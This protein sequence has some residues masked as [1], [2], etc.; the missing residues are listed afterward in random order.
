M[1]NFRGIGIICLTLLVLIMSVSAVTH[2]AGKSSGKAELQEHW[3][4]GMLPEE[5]P[6]STRS[7]WRH[8]LTYAP[9]MSLMGDRLFPRKYRYCVA[10]GGT[11][12]ILGRTAPPPAAW[13]DADFDDSA[14]P[15]SR[16]PMNMVHHMSVIQFSLDQ[17]MI[18]QSCFRTR[19]VVPDPGKVRKLTFTAVFHGGLIVR[20]NGREVGRM[21]I[22][23]DGILAKEGYAEPFPEEACGPVTDETKK[24]ARELK[25]GRPVRG[26]AYSYFFSKLSKQK[27]PKARGLLR[28]VR[29]LL[30]RRIEVNVPKEALRKGINVL[31]LELRLSP[32]RGRIPTGRSGWPHGLIRFVTLDAEPKNAVLS[33][34]KR[35]DGV[36]VWA[37]DI[38]RRVMTEDFL[39][40]G[41]KARSAVRILGARGGRHSAQVLVGTTKDLGAPS[42]KLSDLSGPGGA[43]IPASAVSVRWGRTLD[44][45]ATMV[46][47]NKLLKGGSG[48]EYHHPLSLALLRYRK[49]VWDFRERQERLSYPAP[50][51]L[52][53]P[54]SLFLG[55]MPSYKR[56]LWKEHA[57]GLML[58]DRLSEDP[59]GNVPADTCQPLWITAEIPA[60][61]KAGHYAG[62][63]TVSAAGMTETSFPVRLQVFDWKLPAPKRF[64]YYSG[65]DQSPWS[66]ARIAKVKLW[67]EEHW[68]L[69]EE[70]IKWCGKLGARVAALPVVRDS[71]VDNGKDTMV[72]W[73]KKEDGTYTYDFSIADRYLAL[74][75]KHCH[76]QSDVIVYVLG[77]FKFGFSIVTT[78]PGTVVVLDPETG[79]ENA[80]APIDKEATPEGIRLWVDFCKAARKHLNA[81]GISDDHILFGV[82]HDKVGETN[83][84]LI[85]AVAEELPSVGW[86]R[87][88]HHG[89]KKGKWGGKDV[90]DKVKWDTTL[91]GARQYIKRNIS[92]FAVKKKMMKIAG[93]QTWLPDTKTYQVVSHK[94]WKNP[95]APLSNSMWDNDVTGLA[96][97]SPLWQMRVF[98]EMVITT[99]YRGFAQ[100]CVDGYQRCPRGFGPFIRWL[101]YPT[102]RRVDG[103]IQ[104]EILREGIQDAEARIFLEGKDALPEDV[105]DLLD[106]RAERG[107]RLPLT[108]LDGGQGAE[109][110]AGWQESSWD[111]YAAAARVAGGMVP[112][113]EEKKRFFGK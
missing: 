20:I 81:R 25:I 105:Q 111:L 9:A 62:K 106:R 12:L 103:S 77:A 14:W 65:M 61:A 27:D 91:R 2:G 68:K 60:D 94:G 79:Q 42:A 6:V 22:P 21:Y 36:Q 28:Q 11:A 32:G 101:A 53:G 87:S 107:W 96:L 8:W 4:G 49:P 82:F 17:H 23:A 110:Y 104:F 31:A 57:T 67:S 37:E 55:R 88:S 83:T 113:E 72:K 51:L 84:T 46:D 112:G 16:I 43:V 95:Q 80:F 56:G 76:E 102:A 47:T 54:K 18:R 69:T 34:D 52:N 41:V 38:H 5:S 15:V 13:A 40:P 50:V 75:R 74:W 1:K 30:D 29:D 3:E 99:A 64:T 98:P 45:A 100:A 66:L 73:V 71:E 93:R 70:S 97:L 19:F 85:N 63:L 24:L 109:W 35:P 44:L 78:Q 108:P 33:A 86:A 26:W 58:F 90:A 89:G 10:M 59:A 92:P 39:E 7:Y 48:R